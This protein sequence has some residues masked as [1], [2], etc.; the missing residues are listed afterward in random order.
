MNEGPDIFDVIE[1]PFVLRG[2]NVD[3]PRDMRA[4]RAALR[5]F[6]AFE[7]STAIDHRHDEVRRRLRVAIEASLAAIRAAN[8]NDPWVP[9]LAAQIERLR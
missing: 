5:L 3:I 7:A 9:E 6:G 8:P 1:K 2:G 4:A